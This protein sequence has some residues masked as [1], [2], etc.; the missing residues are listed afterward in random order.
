M[1]NIEI[2][3]SNLKQDKKGNINWKESVN[4]LVPFIYNNEIDFFRIV[5]YGRQHVVLEYNGKVRKFHISAVYSSHIEPLL[6]IYTYK[7]DYEVD[8][9][10]GDFKI[11]K[12]MFIETEVKE[13]KNEF[14]RNLKKKIRGYKVECLK[15]GKQYEVKQKNIQDFKCECSED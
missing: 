13:S 15:C 9:V 14:S 10:V 4:E 12:R 6:D 11:L 7:F 1:S 3:L 5:S 2:D 8:D